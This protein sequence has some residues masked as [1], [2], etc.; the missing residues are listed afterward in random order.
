MVDITLFFLTVKHL[1]FKKCHYDMSQLHLNCS[2]LVY[3]KAIYVCKY[4]IS[5]YAS[6]TNTCI[7]KNIWPFMVK[8]QIVNM[9][10]PSE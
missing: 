6:V 4:I 2:Y 7:K 8:C 10:E 3:S 1:W 9:L 5:A